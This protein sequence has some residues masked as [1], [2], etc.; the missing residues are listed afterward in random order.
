MPIYEYEC[1]GCG[2]VSNFLVRSRQAH[3]PPACPK[4]GHPKMSRL[5]SRFAA[6]SRRW[7]RSGAGPGA[8]SGGEAGGDS[9]PMGAENGF[10][11]LSGLEGLD[12]NDPRSLGRMM[13]QVAEQA[14]EPLEAEMDEVCRRLEAGEDPEEIEEKMADALGADASADDNDDTLYDA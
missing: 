13:R 7:S 9:P 5:F 4:C 10:P 1:D 11:D 3:R 6:A 8:E 12:E 14:G 2:R